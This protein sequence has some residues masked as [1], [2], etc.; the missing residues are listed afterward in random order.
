MERDNSTL[1]LCYA[2]LSVSST[3]KNDCSWRPET[4][5][6]RERFAGREREKYKAGTK[7]AELAHYCPFKET[8]LTKQMDKAQVATSGFLSQSSPLSDSSPY[9]KC[10]VRMPP[11]LFQHSGKDAIK[12]IIVPFR[13]AWNLFTGL[14]AE[15]QRPHTLPNESAKLFRRSFK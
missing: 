10:I 6:N 5:D 3:I 14:D 8:E 13:H 4:R 15:S 11:W 12:R 7:R 9:P 1:L 2:T